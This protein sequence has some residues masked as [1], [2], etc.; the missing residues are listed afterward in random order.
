MSFTAGNVSYAPF[1]TLNLSHNTFNSQAAVRVRAHGQGQAKG[2]QETGHRGT[3][4]IGPTSRRRKTD[5]SP[6]TS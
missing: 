3:C 4:E 5:R 1:T 6:G 2:S